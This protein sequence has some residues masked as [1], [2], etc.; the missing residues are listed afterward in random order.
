MN[1]GFFSQVRRN[2]HGHLNPASKH[3]E[4]CLQNAGE[5]EGSPRALP[6]LDKGS[7]AEKRQSPQ[8]HSQK[9]SAS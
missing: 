6:S 5:E 8:A 9:E 7:S 4:A 3:I 1:R 2:C